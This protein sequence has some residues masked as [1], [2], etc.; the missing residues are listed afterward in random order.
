[1]ATESQI[2]KGVWFRFGAG[3]RSRPGATS[4][5]TET[6]SI[7]SRVLL[8]V[9]VALRRPCAASRRRRG[10]ARRSDFRMSRLRGSASPWPTLVITIA[11]CLASACRQDMHDQPKY[12]PLRQSSFF[13]DERSAR[14]LVAGTVPRGALHDD[15]LLE[16]GR[17]GSADA[18]VF[19]FPVDAPLLARGRE[20]YEIYCAPCH[21]RTGSG[22]GMIVRRGF[23]RPE[24]Y[25]TDRLRSAPVGHF[26]D[27][28]A[29]GFGAM[30]DFADKVNAR[31][32]WAIAAYIR[33]LQLSEH[34]TVADVPAGERGA[35]Q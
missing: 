12:V 18:D 6:Q 5:E 25:H 27:V 23:R 3:L 17:I 15:V 33:A 20:R 1:M 22:D 30:A 35:V 11:A 14:P 16:T 28:M 34:A 29:S 19:P 4:N 7:C 10:G 8:C 26:V 32:R 9:S 24:S 2:R 21:G 13:G 31:D